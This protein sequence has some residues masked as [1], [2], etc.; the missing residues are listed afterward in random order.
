MKRSTWFLVIP[1]LLVLCTVAG[2]SR[3]GGEVWDDTKTASRYMGRGL[4]SLGGKQGESRQINSRDDFG[5]AANWNDD[6]IPLD[7]GGDRSKFALN[8]VP[9]ART[10]PGDPDSPIPGI[11]AFID[12]TTDSELSKI[13][14]NIQFDLNSELV[15]GDEN[16]RHM[17]R[18]SNYLKKHPEL[19][20]F[21]EGHCCE[22]GPQAYNLALGSRRS[23][24][25]RNFL[26]KDG[27]N[28]D[29]LFTISYGKE[30]PLVQ[31]AGEDT[32]RVNRRAQFKVFKR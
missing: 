23:N 16:M 8:Q 5:F 22:R 18:L 31:G 4:R 30:R 12:P 32:L 24:S 10:S 9:Q 3:T 20:V 13:F 17:R 1:A 28:L 21:I 11:E 19:Y 26:V 29:N 6:F 27:V 14:S 15:K 2:C 7:D 25:V